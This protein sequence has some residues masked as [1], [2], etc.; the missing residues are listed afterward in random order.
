[1]TPAKPQRPCPWCKGCE[2]IV[3]DRVLL[4]VTDYGRGFSTVTCTTCGHTAFFT[5]D[6]PDRGFNIVRVEPDPSG[7][8]Y[9]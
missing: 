9:R 3:V 5:L 6:P 7:G 4:E 8:A 2:F 1:M